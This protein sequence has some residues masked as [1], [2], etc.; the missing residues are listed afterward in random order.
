MIR[1]SVLLLLLSHSC[2]LSAN[3]YPD[4]NLVPKDNENFARNPKAKVVAVSDIWKDAKEALRIDLDWKKSTDQFTLARVS[5]EPSGTTALYARTKRADKLGSFKGMLVDQTTGQELAYNT[6]GT[7]H[8]YRKLTRGLS[9]RF[10]SV[11]QD[12]VDFVLFIENPITGEMQKELTVEVNVKDAIRVRPRFDL[13]ENNEL[14]VR[15]LR[16]ATQSPKLIVNV[17]AEGYIKERKSRFWQHAR[18]VVEGFLKNRFPLFDHLE[19][20]AVFKTSKMQLGRAID[21]GPG[22]KTRDSFLGL[23]YAYWGEFT[24]WYNVVYPTAYQKYR[25]GI[26]LVPYDYSIVVIDSKEYWGVGNF[27]ELTAIPSEHPSFT[28]L[29]MH[30]LGHYFGLN[31][32]YETGGRTELEFA[33]GIKEPWSQNITFTTNRDE[34]KWKDIVYPST[35]IPTPNSLWSSMSSGPWGVYEGGYAESLPRNTSHKPGLSCRMSSGSEFC[36]VCF[37]AIEDRINWDLGL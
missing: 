31:E 36:P 4:S 12:K 34:L 23:Y 8:N 25:D 19:F 28:Y 29:L 22:I 30:E 24:R 26:G 15:L 33:P 13:V 5:I 18:N 2:L 7:G 10:P 14:E 17:Y 27:K 32:E 35:P 6:L 16:A 21:Y 11:S 9:F 1:L 37:S 20:R 3:P